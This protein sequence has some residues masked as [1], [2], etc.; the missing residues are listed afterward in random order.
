M[1]EL[2]KKENGK[3]KEKNNSPLPPDIYKESAED[4]YGIN[5]SPQDPKARSSQRV[6]AEADTWNLSDKIVKNTSNSEGYVY[7]R[8]VKE[9]I[10]RQNVIRHKIFKEM[11]E[12]IKDQIDFISFKVWL[13]TKFDEL[14][15]L[16]GEKL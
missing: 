16:A 4:F 7:E 14:D 2:I 11:E 9:F 15:K 10:R 3:M 5:N 1:K 13:I 12:P 8:Y 6:S